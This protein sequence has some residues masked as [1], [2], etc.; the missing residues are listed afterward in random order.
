MKEGL[1]FLGKCTN[2]DCRFYRRATLM[3]IGLEGRFDVSKEMKLCKCGGCKNDLSTIQ[4]IILVNCCWRYRGR[5]QDGVKLHI[6]KHYHV[7]DIEAINIAK[8][9][10]WDYLVIYVKP[11]PQL[12]P[13]DEFVQVDSYLT[14]N[15][16]MQDFYSEVHIGSEAQKEMILTVLLNRIEEKRRILKELESE[17]RENY[18]DLG[19]TGK[20]IKMES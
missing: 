6:L 10:N 15:R 1:Y 9:H 14:S 8:I 16:E 13:K 18:R 3:Y 11:S 5:T 17:T 2:I 7:R 19:A 20:K 12:Q 4:N